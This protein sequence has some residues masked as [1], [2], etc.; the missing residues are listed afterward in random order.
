MYF[1]STFLSGQVRC[2]LILNMLPTSVHR[3]FT[4]AFK[5][6]INLKPLRPAKHKL[7]HRITEGL[8]TSFNTT[9]YVLRTVSLR[10][11]SSVNATALNTI[12]NNQNQTSSEFIR[13]S[14]SSKLRFPVANDAYSM[15]YRTAQLDGKAP[16]YSAWMGA[17]KR[18]KQK[19]CIH[20]EI[21]YEVRQKA[22]EGKTSYLAI[23]RS[24]YGPATCR[25]TDL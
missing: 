13:D 19:L 25:H 9:N 17:S 8:N 4:N 2:T 21:Q 11:V 16:I 23:T 1:C 15:T 10:F 3:T 5:S 7:N 22:Q 12:Q 6:T 18:E 20:W 24:L 14:I